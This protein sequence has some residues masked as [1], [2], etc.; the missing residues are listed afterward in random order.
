MVCLIDVNLEV[1]TIQ[2]AFKTRRM[3]EIIRERKQRP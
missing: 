1:A 3:G 2:R